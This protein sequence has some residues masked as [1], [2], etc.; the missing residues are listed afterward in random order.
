M[1]YDF[2]VYQGNAAKT[3]SEFGLSADVVLKLA[4]TLPAGHNYKIFADNFFTSV[5][6]IER[7]LM[8]GIHY[9]GTVRNGRL[10]NCV[11]KDEKTLSKEGRGSWDSCVLNEPKVAA[12]RW[13]DNRPVT[14]AS[15]FVGPL[16]ITKVQR[17]D[18]VSKSFIEINRPFIVEQYNRSM[19]GVD[20]LDAFV[21]QYR[22]QL[23]SRRWY[24][25]LFW[26][27][28][29]VAL[30]NAWLLYR[31]DCCLLGIPAKEIISRRQFQA[32][33]GSSV[34]LVN[35]EC[36]RKRGRPSIEEQTISKTIKKGRRRGKGHLQTCR[37]MQ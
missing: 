18:K 16:P 26:H 4:S 24:M 32:T 31:R 3:R 13:F 9:T 20:L 34:I 28:I 35:A 7:L 22:F 36:G 14:L 15:T 27:S 25:Y 23:R 11:L 33:V 30:I 17:W 12:V 5:I 21:A 2:D 29:T 1:L 19:G 10:P 8:R 6:L 37:W